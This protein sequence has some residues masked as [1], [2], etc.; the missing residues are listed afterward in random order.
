MNSLLS[1]QEWAL[2]LFDYSGGELSADEFRVFN[3]LISKFLSRAETPPTY[4]AAE[5]KGYSGE[6]VEIGGRAHKKL[7]KA[8]YEGI[9]ALSFA[10]N[11]E[12]SESP[13]Y[14]RHAI[15]NLR[16]N[17]YGGAELSVAVNNG[18]IAFADESFEGLVLELLKIR[19]WSFGFALIDE[20]DKQPDF[21]IQS[22]DN[23]KLN[24]EEQASLMTWYIAQPD[25]KRVKLRSVY[26]WMLLNQQ[27]AAQDVAGQTLLEFIEAKGSHDISRLDNGFVWKVPQ[28]ELKNLHSELKGSG[29]FVG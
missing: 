18:V 12:G 22:I 11:P 25:E 5:G 6:F 15:A 2:G 4:F 1:S 19:S 26:P 9:S 24:P 17:H 10:S 3:D 7:L 13:S 21:H 28:D 14:D 27:Q 16:S 29:V 20:V 23:G 8:N